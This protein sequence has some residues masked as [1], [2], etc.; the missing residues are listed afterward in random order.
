M[1]GIPDF[2]SFIRA[3]KL[4]RRGAQHMGAAAGRYRVARKKPRRD[5]GPAEI[6]DLA[7]TQPPEPRMKCGSVKM[8]AELFADRP[9]PCNQRLMHG[10]PARFG[11]RI[12]RI[13]IIEHDLSAA[14]QPGHETER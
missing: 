12:G 7:K 14:R 10:T 11:H 9:D 3:T 13:D 8:V 5:L 4:Q 6:L 2:A 1:R